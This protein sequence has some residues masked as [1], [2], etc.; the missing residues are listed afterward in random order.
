[1]NNFQKYIKSYEIEKGI[2]SYLYIYYIKHFSILRI[3]KCTIY[4][5]SNTY[6]GDDD[7]GR[8]GNLK[9]RI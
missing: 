6:M 3:N 4:A 8:W 2:I 7:G 9:V 5:S 1:M